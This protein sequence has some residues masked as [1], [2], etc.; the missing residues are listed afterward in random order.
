M[1][2]QEAYEQYNYALKLGQKYYRECVVRGK[3]P[4]QQALSDVFNENLAAAKVNIGLV[5]I[6]MEQIVGTTTSGRGNAFAG[7]FMPLLHDSTE[8]AMKW[9]ALCEAHLEAGGI[10]DPI[11]CYEYMGRFYVTEGNK[12][13][14]VLKSYDAPSVAGNVTRIV[15]TWSEDEAVQVYYEFIPFYDLSGL[16]DVNFSRKG[17]YAKLQAR[18]GFA[19]DHVWTK[20]E[21][22]E[23]LYGFRRFKAAFEK[24]NTEKLD[25]TPGDALL[26]WLQ[27]NP[28]EDL[29]KTDLVKSLSAAWP[30]VR[31][32]A[33]GSA[34]AVSTEPVEEKAG[35]TRL[36]GLG[37]PNHLQIAFIH[38]M[39]PEQS[40]WTATH[41]S[42]RKQLE[43]AMG[44][45]VSVKS[46]IC[47]DEEPLTVMERAVEEGAQVIFATT[48]PLIAACRQIAARYPQVKVLN[49]SVSMPYSGVRTYYGRMYEAK[50]ITG[51]IAG[52]MAD[53]NKIGYVA[54][55]PIIGTIAS[56]NAF[57]LGVRM[58]N[59]N[60][61]IILRWSCLPGNP[62]H[63]LM[64]EGVSVVSNRE[65]ATE[66]PYW[67]WEW[68]TYKVEE[69]G[70]LL[71][72]S[73]PVWNWGKFYEGVIQTIFDGGWNTL[74]GKEAQAINYWW[75]MRSGVID[76][77]LNPDLPEGS[78]HLSQIL[79]QGLMSG[80]IDPFHARMIDQNGEV[81]N[82]G[83]RS[84]T[85]EDVMDVD[86]LLD[87]VEG[88]IPDFE[89]ILPVSQQLVRLL[90][91]KRNEILPTPE[92]VIL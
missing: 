2:R 7:N 4:Y 34:I 38:A 74:G 78:K 85:V 90:G 71:P 28:V 25:I 81:R 17:S 50:F 89:E 42:G 84:F 69:T 12:R 5:D 55:Y 37:R 58:T 9:T 40:S 14:S 61:K 30:D 13:V 45:R 59:P 87:N 23:F 43:E 73:S 31:I 10:S 88:S 65:S 91:L 18:L 33:N 62:V 67:A 92:E 54:N 83:D 36:F 82:D 39:N 16:Y 51:A 27:M 24:L 60:A 68:G 26:I 86:W 29:Q 19:P 72:L 48:P 3:Y 63:S 22:S 52:A 41:E 66:D 49:C 15:P 79:R 21:R 35:I 76:V 46:Y 56:I 70:N 8:F 57:A 53:N 77:T 44:E 1:S 11:V 32:F 47:E 80:A 64:E 20:D 6:P 75:G